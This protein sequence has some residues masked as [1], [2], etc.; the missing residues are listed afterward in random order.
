MKVPL[1]IALIVL[2][3]SFVLLVV[4]ELKDMSPLYPFRYLWCHG[5]NLVYSWAILP[6]AQ[7]V[8]N[9]DWI[10]VHRTAPTDPQVNLLSCLAE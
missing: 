10:Q 5:Q 4:V 1:T 7:F 9:L 8:Q 2:L 6:V 3:A